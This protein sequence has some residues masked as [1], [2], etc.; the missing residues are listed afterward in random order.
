MFK[1]M[2]KNVG[3]S[4]DVVEDCNPHPPASSMKEKLQ[5]P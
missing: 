5:A 4:G 3:F 1:E 2:L